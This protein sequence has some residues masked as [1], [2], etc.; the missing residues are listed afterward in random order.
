MH[1]YSAETGDGEEKEISQGKCISYLVALLEACQPIVQ[2]E[3]RRTTHQDVMNLTSFSRVLNHICMVQFT[4]LVS[5]IENNT[6]S[7]CRPIHRRL[8]FITANACSPTIVLIYALCT[9][10]P[11]IA[12][13]IHGLYYKPSIQGLHRTIPRLR[14]SMLCA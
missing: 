7:I 4:V 5:S 6:C 8:F 2:R 14:K 10:N 11:W 1:V 13:P 3:T 12:R 9:S